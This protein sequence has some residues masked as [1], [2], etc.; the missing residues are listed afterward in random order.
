MESLWA[1]PEPGYAETQPRELKI[2]RE[3][4]LPKVDGERFW[5]QLPSEGEGGEGRT[6]LQV[7]AD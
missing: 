1:G 6:M 3:Y 2:Q 4:D 5:V 7:K